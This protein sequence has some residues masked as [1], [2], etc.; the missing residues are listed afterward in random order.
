MLR[1]EMTLGQ[2]MWP[3]VKMFVTLSKNFMS[4][5]DRGRNNVKKYSYWH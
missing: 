1:I 5:N 4:F 3:Q 2:K